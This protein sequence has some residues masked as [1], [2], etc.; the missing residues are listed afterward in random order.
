MRLCDTG[1]CGPSVVEA[2]LYRMEAVCWRLG[3]CVCGGCWD[4]EPERLIL[5]SQPSCA[6]TSALATNTAD[7]SVDNGDIAE[8]SDKVPDPEDQ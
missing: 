6:V 8:I 4:Q 2:G 3:H 7:N 5:L 1:L